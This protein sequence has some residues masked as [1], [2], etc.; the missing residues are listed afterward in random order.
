[1]ANS[2]FVSLTRMPESIDEIRLFVNKAFKELDPLQPEIRFESN[3][4]P[5]AFTDGFIVVEEDNRDN[6]CW[7]SINECEVELTEDDECTTLADVKTRGSWVFA[8]IV[9][10][11]FCR[12]AG[13]TVF[14]DAGEL[15]GQERY[16]AESLR[17]VLEA[18]KSD[19]L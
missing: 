17:N 9:A 13:R 4:M 18:R 11:A 8:G 3:V 7:V 12:M 14:N 6:Q 15:D 10:Y 1:M 5:S 16:T 19:L 2:I